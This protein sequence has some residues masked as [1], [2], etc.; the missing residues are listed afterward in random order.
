VWSGTIRTI[1]PDNVNEAIDSYVKSVI[2][3]LKAKN[4]LP[5]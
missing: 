3:A 5:E 2:A 4:I 1:D